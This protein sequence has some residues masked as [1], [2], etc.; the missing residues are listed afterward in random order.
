MTLNYLLGS[1]SDLYEVE[2]VIIT[3]RG[4]SKD[5]DSVLTITEHLISIPR[6]EMLGHINFLWYE[7]GDYLYVGMPV[8]FIEDK[9]YDVS[10]RK[11]ILIKPID[12]KWH[13]SNS[14]HLFDTYCEAAY[15]ALEH[16]Y[17]ISD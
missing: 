14:T 1:R 4:I 13:V 11:I 8:I 12:G 6:Y 17:D 16:G 15:W 10:S 9:L 2:D 5:Y 3:F 7:E